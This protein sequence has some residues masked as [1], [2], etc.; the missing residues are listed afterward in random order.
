[1]DVVPRVSAEVLARA[2]GHG[3]G[4]LTV[5]THDG[6]PFQV[7]DGSMLPLER[8]SLARLDVDKAEITDLSAEI[9]LDPSVVNDPV[10]RFALWGFPSVESVDRG[11][12][13]KLLGTGSPGE[14]EAE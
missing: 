11:R 3:S 9:A 7:A 8:R 13:K 1:M 10:G 14:G 4:L 12:G 2:L 5:F 6:P